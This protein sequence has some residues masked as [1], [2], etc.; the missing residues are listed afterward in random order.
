[1]Y[2]KTWYKIPL[3]GEMVYSFN[4]RI[5]DELGYVEGEARD[6]VNFVNARNQYKQED[7][8]GFGTAKGC[9]LTTLQNTVRIYSG[10]SRYEE[11]DVPPG[12]YRYESDYSFPNNWLVPME[13]REDAVLDLVSTA[14]VEKDINNFLKSK[15]IYRELKVIYKKGFLFYGP[16]GNGKTS[17][18]RNLIRRFKDE[19][20]CIYIPHQLP[21]P[22]CLSAFKF[23][24][25]SI[26]KM[27]IFE[28]L[29]VSC[30][31]DGELRQLLSFLDGETSVDNSITIATTNYPESIPGN[32]IERPGRFDKVTYFGPPNEEDK[33]KLLNYFLGK[34]PDKEVVRLCKD[35]SVAEIK[36]LC[37]SVRTLGTTFEV[38]VYNTN[39]RKQIAKNDFKELRSSSIGF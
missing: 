32:V 21:S 24:N 9:E 35:M 8:G 20:I 17:F 36:E 29:A 34:A 12:F 30:K 6:I 11:T 23:M 16:P 33:A 19:F 39:R 31:H 5:A 1:M 14:E 13:V 38:E 37:L 7:K 27:F 22:Y 28:E 3:N 4:T 15:E 10:E 2:K 25:N 26:P 18:I